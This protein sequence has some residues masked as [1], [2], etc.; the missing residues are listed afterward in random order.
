METTQTGLVQEHVFMVTDADQHHLHVDHNNL[1]RPLGMARLYPTCDRAELPKPRHS[2]AKQ[3]DVYNT[4]QPLPSSLTE[5]YSDLHLLGRGVFCRTTWSDNQL[6]QAAKQLDDNATADADAD[7]D[8]GDA[9]KSKKN[10][11]FPH[12]NGCT[13]RTMALP[14]R[15]FEKNQANIADEGG[16]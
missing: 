4:S 3:L 2:D 14:N 15:L 6:H 5:V 16:A 13:R 10:A 12:P 8:A 9:L 1:G 11:F 7:A